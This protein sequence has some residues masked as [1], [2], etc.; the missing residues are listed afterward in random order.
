VALLGTFLF[1]VHPERIL[2]GCHIWPDTLLAVTLAALMVV[3]TLPEVPATALLAGGLCALGVLT[4]VDFL[5]ALPLFLAAWRISSGPPGAI[6]IAALLAPPLGALVLL[7]VRNYRRYGIPLPDTTWAFNLMVAR[8]EARLKSDD[9]FEIER[10]VGDAV[11]AWRGLAPVEAARRGLGALGEVLRSPLRFGRGIVRRLLILVGPD[12][13]IRQK[14]L[15][16]DAAYPDLGERQ[17]RWWEAALE[18]ATPLLVTVVLIGAAAGR[19]IPESYAW[20]SLGLAAAAILFHTRTRYRVT[21]LPALSL[22]AAQAIVGLGSHLDNTPAIALV[23]AG[24]AA[25]FWA[26]LRIRIPDDLRT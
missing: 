14:L 19:C 11:A 18:I 3:S 8:E 15:P 10:T 2:L 17:R 25:L 22:V 16:R 21:L 24:G 6:A 13:F 12:T 7:S 5:L 23:S 26:L 4:R 9:H 1:A 20:P